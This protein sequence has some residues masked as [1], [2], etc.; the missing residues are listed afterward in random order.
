MEVCYKLAWYSPWT[1]QGS[2][3]VLPKEYSPMKACSP[4]AYSCSQHVT[5]SVCISSVLYSIGRAVM[6]SRSITWNYSAVLMSFWPMHAMKWLWC[7]ISPGFQAKS[8]LPTINVWLG[9]LLHSKIHKHICV[10]P[11]NY[12]KSSLVRTKHVKGW[13]GWYSIFCGKRKQWY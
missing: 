13:G 5:S 11:I 4:C 10:L 12:R 8:G 9:P 2:F 1:S 7:K 6:G 3:K